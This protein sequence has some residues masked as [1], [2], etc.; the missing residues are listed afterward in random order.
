MK[1]TTI[2]FD[3]S[4]K[5]FSHRSDESLKQSWFLFRVMSHPFLV[6]VLSRITI[7]AMMIKLPISWLIRKSIFKQFCG[8]ENINESLKVAGELYSNKIGAI[9]DYSVEGKETDLDFER[10]KCEV[11]KIIYK[12]KDNPAIPYTSLKVTGIGRFGLL[13]ELN[14]NTVQSSETEI[15]AARLHER[16]ACVC[17]SANE[18]GVPVYFDAEESWIQDAIDRMAEEMMWKYNTEK[19]IVLTTIQMYRWDRLEYLIDLVR[20]ARI[21][22]RKVGVKLVRGAYWEKENN[23][24]ASM[25]RK[26]AVH[27][28]KSDTDA[29]FNSAVEFCLNN[30]DVVTLCAGTHN[31][32][33]T[34]SLIEKMKLLGIPNDHPNVYFSQLYGMSDNITYNLASQG[35]NV[36]KYLPYGPIKSVIPYLIRRAEENTSIAGQMGRELTLINQELSRRKEQKLIR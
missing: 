4:A 18:H 17:N 2:S 3:N 11:L 12:A 31:Q 10:T 35:Y 19:A 36:T 28:L 22:G 30:I 34:Y 8:G 29:D 9:L 23:Y 16:I 6:K 24:A 7:W 25:N 1:D 26:S 14:N 33:S 21:K 32:E 20:Q 13:E 5:T 27:Q 15:E